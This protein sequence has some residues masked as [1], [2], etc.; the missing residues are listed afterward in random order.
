MKDIGLAHIQKLNI[1][2]VR[3]SRAIYNELTKKYGQK[4]AKDIYDR[5]VMMDE[6]ESFYDICG[7]DYDLT[8]LLAGSYDAD[9]VRNTCNWIYENMESFGNRIL[10]VG[11]GCGFITTFLGSLFPD[12]HIISIDRN[13]SSIAIAKRNIENLGL[14]NVEVLCKDVADLSGNR[15]DTVISVRTMQENGSPIDED[16]S[17]SF[18]E[19]AEVYT[20]SK[21]GYGE[22]LAS[23]VENSGTLITVERTRFDPLFLAW[24]EV[25]TRVGLVVDLTSHNE[26]NC[27]EVGE[28]STFEAFVAKKSIGDSPDPFEIFMKF[29]KSVKSLNRSEYDGWD[30]K[31]IYTALAG[32]IIAEYDIINADQ[33][34]NT[35]ITLTKNKSDEKKLMLY[36]SYDKGATL[37]MYDCSMKEKVLN[38]MEKQYGSLDG[39]DGFAVRRIV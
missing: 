20:N 16:L 22:M 38:E 1:R 26:L 8:M 21:L 2:S 28:N 15:F 32:D 4:R 17:M 25:L 19:L 12:K 6:S 39:K 10:E 31:I 30:A 3:D 24:I 23:L 35:H 18:L 14:S 29:Y 13:E 33:D 5:F 27:N 9:I 36:C 11:S 34:V 7:G 37:Q